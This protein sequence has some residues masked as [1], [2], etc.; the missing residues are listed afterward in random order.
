M[1]GPQID[2]TTSGDAS[3]AYMTFGEGD[4][5]LLFV[6]GFVG[7]LEIFPELPEAKAF[8]DRLGSFARVVTSTSAAWGCRSALGVRTRSRGWWRT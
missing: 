4:L 8:M 7:H 3:I 2:Y 1:T 6:G 5:D